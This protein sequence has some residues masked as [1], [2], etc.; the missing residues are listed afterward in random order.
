MSTKPSQYAYIVTDS[1]NGQKSRWTRV[2]AVWPHK[3]GQGFDLVI[4]AGMA[5][6]GRV[7]CLPPKE[8]ADDK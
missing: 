2:G 8:D 4:P 5:V 7:V 1:D 3:N 6:Y